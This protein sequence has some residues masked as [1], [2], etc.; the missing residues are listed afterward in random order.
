MDYY[1]DKLFLGELWKYFGDLGLEKSLRVQDIMNLEDNAK[2][3]ADGG[4]M[5]HEVSERNVESPL[6]TLGRLVVLFCI[7]DL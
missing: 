6:K 7:E 2:S 5:P 4:S 3:I 1:C